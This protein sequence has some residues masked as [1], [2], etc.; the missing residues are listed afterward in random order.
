MWAQIRTDMIF[1]GD[2]FKHPRNPGLTLTATQDPVIIGHGTETNVNII[3]KARNGRHMNVLTRYG[4]NI[5]IWL[6]DK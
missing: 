5:T 4:D 3:G 2:K 1:K 6:E